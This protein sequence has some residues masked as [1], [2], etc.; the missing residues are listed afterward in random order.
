MVGRY[1]FLFFP[2]AD[3]ITDFRDHDDLHVMP[4]SFFVFF[5]SDKT[6]EFI[7][8]NNKKNERTRNAIA[9]YQWTFIEYM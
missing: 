2:T 5:S 3:R 7:N 6:Q 9:Q 8:S 4:T 1:G